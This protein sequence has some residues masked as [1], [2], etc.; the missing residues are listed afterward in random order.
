MLNFIGYLKLVNGMT[1]IFYIIPLMEIKLLFVNGSV[2][3]K[4][5]SIKQSLLPALSKVENMIY[6]KIVEKR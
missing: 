5:L 4:M 1:V 2:N 3:M 6:V